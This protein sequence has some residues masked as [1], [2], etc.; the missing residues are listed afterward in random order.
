M[1]ENRIVIDLDKEFPK[2]IKTGKGRIVLCNS[3]SQ[4]CR[5]LL[6]WGY[7]DSTEIYF[8][9]GKTLCF[10]WPI[11]IGD[12]A[13]LNPTFARDAGTTWTYANVVPDFLRGCKTEEKRISDIYKLCKLLQKVTKRKYHVDH[14]WPKC[15]G[16]PHWSGN[17]QVIPAFDNMSK[18][19]EVN[20]EVKKTIQEGLEYARQC[21]ERGEV[22]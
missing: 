4:Y 18:H 19:S 6:E 14:M 15:D 7:K 12:W 10:T 11:T 21:Y 13:K 3:T 8:Y 5:Y 16:G 1:T 9:R 22:C 2:K 17:L 20:E